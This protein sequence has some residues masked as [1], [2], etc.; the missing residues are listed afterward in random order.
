MLHI[1]AS[2]VASSFYATSLLRAKDVPEYN[3][4]IRRFTFL[5]LCVQDTVSQAKAN[6]SQ[7]IIKK[8]KGWQAGKNF[9]FGSQETKRRHHLKNAFRFSS[10]GRSTFHRRWGLNPRC[11]GSRALRKRIAGEFGLQQRARGQLYSDWRQLRMHHW[12]LAPRPGERARG[13]ET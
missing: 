10:V 3:V 12:P 8:R 13:L 9:F 6:I 1:R 5:C 11:V 2:F 4:F 7:Q